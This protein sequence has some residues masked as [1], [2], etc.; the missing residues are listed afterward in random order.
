MAIA[1]AITVIT[2]A[3]PFVW[4]GFPAGPDDLAGTMRL[5]AYVTTGVSFWLLVSVA[6]LAKHRFFTPKDIDAAAG[7]SETSTARV[8]QSLLQ[9]TLEQSVLAIAIYGAWFALAPPE[10]RLLPLLCVALFGLGRLLFYLGYGRGAVAR[11]L[12]F[13]L[14]FYPTVGLFILLL[15]FSAA[16][17]IG[18]AQ[19]IPLQTTFCLDP[20][21]FG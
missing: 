18:A 2:L 8:L 9:N 6:R 4:P 10:A 7:S 14:T 13:A 17:L 5:W 20:S 21:M 3:L 11:S 19:A 12:G 1:V 16:R 15:G